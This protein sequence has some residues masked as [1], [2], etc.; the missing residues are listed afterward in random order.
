MGLYYF[1]IRGQGHSLY[2]PLLFVEVLDREL[3]AVHF[4]HTFVLDPLA[5]LRLTGS[6]S[7]LARG[8]RP[9]SDKSE[10]H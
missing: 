10:R 6:K 7:R 3:N 2:I 4:C 8:L 1:E 9:R 5:S